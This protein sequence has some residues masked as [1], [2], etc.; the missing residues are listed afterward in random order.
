MPRRKPVLFDPT[1]TAA[2]IVE[3]LRK[4]HEGSVFVAEC[5]LGSS[6]SSDRGGCLR[7]DAFTM[8]PTWTK[9]IT[10]GYEIKVSRADFV[11]DKKWRAY[12]PALKWFYF[13]AP[14]GVLRVADIEDPAG[15]IEIGPPPYLHPR[16]EPYTHQVDGK[17]VWADLGRPDGE[18]PFSL[19]IAK[20]AKKMD[21]DDAALLNVLKYVA[22]W[23]VAKGKVTTA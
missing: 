20:K 12:L 2:R 3:R 4:H 16:P 22:F 5:K 8:T 6:W 21:V 7:M 15:L 18:I 1:V 9:T 13:V 19:T 23:R 10:T 11:R 14:V 17:T